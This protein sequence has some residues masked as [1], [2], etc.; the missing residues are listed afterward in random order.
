GSV[1]ATSSNVARG[2][3][4]GQ[5]EQENRAG[6]AVREPRHRGRQDGGG[7]ARRLGGGAAPGPPL[8]PGNEKTGVP[9]GGALPGRPRAG[10][11]PPVRLRQGAVLLGAAG[12]GVHLC[13]RVA[14]LALAGRPGPARR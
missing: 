4:G 8:V 12:G 5:R 2:A 13:L 9:A 7:A 14:V 6:G 10:R 11:G 1:Q 3:V